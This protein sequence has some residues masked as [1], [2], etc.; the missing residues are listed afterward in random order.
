VEGLEVHDI[1]KEQIWYAVKL[2]QLVVDVPCF[3]GDSPANGPVLLE[4][5]SPH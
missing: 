1:W 3:I 4:F 5:S 2:A